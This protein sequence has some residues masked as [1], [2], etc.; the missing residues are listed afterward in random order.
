MLPDVPSPAEIAATADLKTELKP[1]TDLQ[2]HHAETAQAKEAIPGTQAVND[3]A[4]KGVPATPEA[5]KECATCKQSFPYA[6]QLEK[7]EFDRH[8]AT[9]LK[10]SCTNP[11][12]TFESKKA[13]QEHM[14]A[15]HEEK[16]LYK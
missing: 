5:T 14:K 7:S 2:Q 1:E 9:H 3:C 15:N 8:C 4:T 16:K 13:Y 10:C 12:V 6:S 11:T